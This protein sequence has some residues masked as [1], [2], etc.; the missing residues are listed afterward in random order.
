[1]FMRRFFVVLFAF[2]LLLCFCSG[3]AEGADTTYGS[4][5]DMMKDWGKAEYLDALSSEFEIPM[6]KSTEKKS[7]TPISAAHLSIPISVAI[8]AVVIV[9]TFILAQARKRKIEDMDRQVKEKEWK[10]QDLETAISDKDALYKR[11]YSE[12]KDAAIAELNNTKSKLEHDCVKLREEYAKCLAEY[13]SMSAATQKLNSD[14]ISADKRVKTLKALAKSIQLAQQEMAQY[15]L[16]N[17][18]AQEIKRIQALDFDEL[19]PEPELNCLDQKE[20]AAKYRAIRKQ[21][22]SVCTAYEERYTTKNYIAIYKLMV[23]ALESEFENVL[24]KL[25]FGRLED[26]IIA[27]SVLTDKCYAIA[28][29]GNQTIAPTVRSF[30]AQV[31]A[32]YI[33]AL[34]VEYEYYIQRERAKEEQRAIREQMRQESEERKRLELERKKIESEENKYQS[35]IERIVA[36]MQLAHD[37]ELESLRKRLDEVTALRADVAEKKEEIVR[38]QNGKAGTVYIISNIGSFGEHVYKIG[39]TR[40]I[41]PQERVDELG[42]ASVPFPFDVHSFIF[43]KDAVSLETALHKELNDRRVNKVNL[44]KEFFDVTIDELKAIV[45]RID[46]T[47]PFKTTALAEQY[48][49]SI[50]V[51]KNV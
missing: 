22:I 45:E 34:H 10:L 16:D 13:N 36:Q 25:S 14:M 26:G 8:S 47:A 20:L 39:M 5:H 11:A 24:H 41:N 51:G 38:L 9:I 29:D 28:T 15:P 48:R 31:K 18:Y 2:A 49:Q 19:L 40:R 7:E 30:I 23:L 1:M 27:V 17:A 50:S 12:A 37:A 4:P 46:P 32:L 44:R 6:P 43:S 21:I 35:E 3:N 33:D 42:D